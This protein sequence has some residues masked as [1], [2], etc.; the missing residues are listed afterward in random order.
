MLFY[1]FAGLTTLHAKS[2]SQIRKVS[3]EVSD[4]TLLNVLDLLQEKSGYT[5]LFSSSDIQGIAGISLNVKE[6]SVAEVLKECLAG[7]DLSYE[8]NGDLIILKKQL[9]RQ[10]PQV[11]EKC[12]IQGIVRDKRGETLPGVSVLLK[13]TALGV[14]TDVEGR[15]KFEIP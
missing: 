15:F 10:L 8:L 12:L 9:L 14:T 4:Q 1:W 13:N 11:Q 2:F 5:F 3:V 7:T 6:K